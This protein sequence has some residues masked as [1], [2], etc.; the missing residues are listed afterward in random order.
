MFWDKFI[1]LCVAEHIA[2]NAVCAKLGFSTA[3]ATHWKRGAQ[4][5]SASLRRIANYF[6]VPEEYFEDG[7]AEDAPIP[8]DSV[9]I[10]IYGKVAAG[11]PISAI[12]DVEDYEEIP[13]R[14]AAGGEY[15]ALR[16]SGDSMEPKIESG[17][18]VIVRRQEDC[19]S[20]DIAIVMIGGEDA[21]CKRLKKLGS[22]IMLISSNPKYDPMVF[23]GEEV[24][25]LPVTV[26]GKVVELRA[27][28]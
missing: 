26:L 18:V 22:G 27:K 14:M 10:P 9:R 20:D 11:I 5:S 23:S 21:T 8:A 6:G 7:A 2:P 3:A 4:P 15:F 13:R 12:T 25:S 24:Q 16:I 1:T 28:L 17:D 19:E